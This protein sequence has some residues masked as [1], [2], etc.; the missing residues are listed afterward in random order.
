MWH[1]YTLPGFALKLE[2]RRTPLGGVPL[3]ADTQA[4]VTGRVSRGSSMGGIPWHREQRWPD[5]VWTGRAGQQCRGPALRRR[6][7]SVR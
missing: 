5:G 2:P 4:A 1:T 3:S 6:Q 7:D